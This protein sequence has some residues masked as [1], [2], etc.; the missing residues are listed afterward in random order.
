M[1][2]IA[3]KLTP[4][5]AALYDK[6]QRS[7]RTNLDRILSVSHEGEDAVSKLTQV[8]LAK[9]TGIARSTVTKVLSTTEPSKSNPDL[10]T[11]CRLAAVLKVPP[12][13]LL[14]SP[15]DWTRLASAISGLQ[16]APGPEVSD[17]SLKHLGTDQVA[18]RA[19]ALAEKVQPREVPIGLMAEQPL[20]TQREWQAEI[21][22]R[23]R[24]ARQSVRAMSVAPAW[25]KINGD[26][27]SLFTIC[28]LMGA[29]TN[30]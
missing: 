9:D 3:N 24:H 15:D 20:K 29:A 30:I 11:L 2:P 28:V 19:V 8:D 6:A 5:A 1:K 7:L 14:M 4:D 23:Q 17:Q 12:A 16:F 26:V 21:E 18:Q 10:R 13:F 25:A 22:Q 27:D